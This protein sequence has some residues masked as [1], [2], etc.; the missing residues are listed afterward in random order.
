M[1][2]AT[3]GTLCTGT[4]KHGSPAW[5]GVLSSIGYL[6]MG[7]KMNPE[8]DFHEAILLLNR[9]EMALSVRRSPLDIYLESEY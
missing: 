3:F 5:E 1:I 9:L 6:L 8:L 4:P 2:N 7:I